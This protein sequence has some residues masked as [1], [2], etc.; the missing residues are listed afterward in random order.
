MKTTNQLPNTN[1]RHDS[2][3]ALLRC[4][5]N[6]PKTDYHYHNASLAGCGAGRGATFRAPSFRDISRDYLEREARNNF[7]TE[8]ALFATIMITAALPLLNGAHA[9]AGL[10][11]SLGVL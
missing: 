8:T 10:I 3:R 6:F 2:S 11:R 9:V 1:K 4:G 7:L 5:R